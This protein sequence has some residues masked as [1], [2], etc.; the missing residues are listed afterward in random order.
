MPGDSPGVVSRKHS[1]IGKK[2]EFFSIRCTPEEKIEIQRC[3]Q[4]LGG[5]G[6]SRYLINLHHRNLGRLGGSSG[7]PS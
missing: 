1:W 2:T 7:T 6:V 3:A 5:L 4:Q